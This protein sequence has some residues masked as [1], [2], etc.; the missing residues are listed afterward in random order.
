MFSGMKQQE[1]DMESTYGGNWWAVVIRGIVAI[2]FGVAALIW[3]AIT[4]FVL[5]ALFAA[6]VIVE[7]A[8]TIVQA[9]RRAGR[10]GS[11]W[12]RVARGVIGILFGLAVL[13]WPGITAIILLY[14]IA[15]WAI[16]TGVL[17][18]IA[19]IALRDEISNEW[20]MVAG[21]VISLI[22]GILI[23]AFPGAGALTLILFIG[24]YA[25]VFGIVLLITGIQARSQPP[26]AV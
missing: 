8:F 6:F 16:V 2:I 25:I 20:W 23:A 12:A 9:F 15:F 26:R 17:E 24:I 13:F 1:V 11:F 3:P 21:G 5:I 10:G 22:F 4:L 18:I 7:G 19:G 14:L